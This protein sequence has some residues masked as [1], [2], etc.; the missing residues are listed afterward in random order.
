MGSRKLPSAVL[1]A[2]L[3]LGLAAPVWAAGWFK[4][5]TQEQGIL[6]VDEAIELQPALWQNGELSI[7]LDAAAGVY[8]YRDKLSV[9]VVAPEDYRLS[10]IEIPQG[11]SH[12][13][14][15]FGD[16]QILRDRILITA[17]TAAAAP[18]QVRVRYQGCAENLVCYPPQTRLLDVETLP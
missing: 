15:H 2:A 18:K 1:T 3:A 9:E 10:G 5:T 17:R 12:H 6:P 7:G 11:E 14:D 16:V 13:D 8:L 4:D